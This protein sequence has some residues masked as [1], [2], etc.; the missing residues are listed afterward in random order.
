M[1]SK[2]EALEPLRILRQRIQKDVADA[3]NVEMVS[4]AFMIGDEE[5]DPDVAQVVFALTK[6][7]LKDAA[8]LEKQRINDEFERMMAGEAFIDKATDLS[9]DPLDLWDEDD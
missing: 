5:G 2:D 9:D 4:C 3:Q 6:D 7:S 1:T 8:E